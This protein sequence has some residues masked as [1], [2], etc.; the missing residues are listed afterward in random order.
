[1][2]RY[3]VDIEK[4]T[5]FMCKEIMDEFNLDSLSQAIGFC[6]LSVHDNMKSG[7]LTAL[8]DLNPTQKK[9]NEILDI[10]T[11]MQASQDL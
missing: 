10:L 3:R 8:E 1:M 7:D 9:L 6:V 5:H 11:T 2:G 4:S